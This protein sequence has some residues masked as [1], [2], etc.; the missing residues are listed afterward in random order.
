MGSQTRAW[1]P[2]LHSEMRLRKGS[3]QKGLRSRL[4]ALLR[5]SWR[6]DSG[7]SAG[8]GRPVRDDSHDLGLK[9]MGLGS[10]RG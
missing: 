4:M 10:G 8:I 2:Q 1:G 7:V 9:Y 3:E 5:F 6:T